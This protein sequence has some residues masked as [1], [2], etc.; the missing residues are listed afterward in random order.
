MAAAGAFFAGVLERQ[1][2]QRRGEQQ[3][4]APAGRIRGSQVQHNACGQ[5]PGIGAQLTLRSGIAPADS[6]Q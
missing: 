4:P 2:D 6:F 5:L 3:V 1:D